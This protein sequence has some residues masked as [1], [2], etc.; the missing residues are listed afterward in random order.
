MARV[1]KNIKANKNLLVIKIGSVIKLLFEG[2]KKV[3]VKILIIKIL[4]YSAIKIRANSPLLYS[5]LNP[6]TSSDSPSARSN[7]VRLV[8]AN[9]VINQQINKGDRASPIGTGCER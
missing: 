6:E 7:G 3:A 1:H 5:I 8:S 9:I 4:V 2:R